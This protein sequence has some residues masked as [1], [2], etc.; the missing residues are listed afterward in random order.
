VTTAAQRSEGPSIDGTAPDAPLAPPR[1][2]SFA[3]AGAVADA[4]LYE[5]YLLY[6]YR[7]SSPKNRVRW[8]FGVLAPRAVIEAQGPPDTGV[9]GSADSWHQQTEC[10]LEAQDGATVQVRLRFLQV[11]QRAVEQRT[12][13]G[14]FAAVDALEADGRTHLSFDEALPREFDVA[15]PLA[16]LLAGERTVVLG[17]PGGEEVEPLADAGRIVRRRRPVTARLRL[18]A[19]PADAPFPLVRLRVTV[20]NAVDGLPAATARPEALRVSLVAAHCLIALR[21]GQFLSLLEPPLWAAAAAGECRNVHTFPVLA[22]NGGTV[23]DVLLSSPILLYDHPQIAPESPGP[24]FDSGEIDEILSLRT[25]T[26]TDEEKA[27]AR[28]TDPEAAAILDRVDN[29]PD[30][31]WAKLHGAVRS[32]R[33]VIREPDHLVVGGARV[34]AGSRVRL[35]PRRH[36][37]DAQDVFLTGRTATVDR[38]LHDVDGTRF[39]AVALDDDPGADLIAEYGRCYQF[40][41]DEIEALP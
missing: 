22:S 14:G 26:L 36:G 8:Q 30:E 34:T 24:L 33:P 41:A 25:M 7:R 35:R 13:D 18:A 3:Q 29:L 2:E 23:A 20:E 16:D 31:M 17:A 1:T 39:V 27:E 5:G 21:G 4:V 19:A 6:P 32:L 10:L 9:A 11:Q 37:T 15:C 28:A 40:T 12:V 38:V